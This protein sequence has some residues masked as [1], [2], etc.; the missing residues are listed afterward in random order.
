MASTIQ[1][2]YNSSRQGDLEEIQREEMIAAGFIQ[3]KTVEANTPLGWFINAYACMC[4]NPRYRL[5]PT[6][7][8][9]DLSQNFLNNEHAM[10]NN[11]E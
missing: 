9:K 5:I 1:A 2:N 8:E 11:M 7:E 4:V 3:E 6:K 10:S